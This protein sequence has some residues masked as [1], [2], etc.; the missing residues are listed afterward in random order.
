MMDD[1]AHK[2]DTLL[3]R[4]GKALDGKAAVVETHRQTDSAK[5]V[6]AEAEFRSPAGDGPQLQLVCLDEHEVQLYFG[7]GTNRWELDLDEDSVVFIEGVAVAVL[8]GRWDQYSAPGRKHLD[9]ELD[10]GTVIETTTYSAPTG[11]MPLPGWLRRAK[12]R[13]GRR[14][15][16]V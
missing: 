4:L 10:D 11:L 16:G 15:T 1:L 14:G 6:F 2:W 5:T 9:V 12:A 7:D 3:V 8:A 13:K